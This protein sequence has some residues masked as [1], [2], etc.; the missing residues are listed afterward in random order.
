M[1][2]S[3]P[4]SRSLRK[5]ASKSSGVA[6]SAA[7]HVVILAAGQG[8][9][10]KSALPKVLHPIGGRPMLAHVLDTVAQLEAAACH[11]VHGHGADSV[12]TWCESAYPNAAGL[13]W[14]LQQ[15]QV[16]T[17][18]AVQQA[19]P[20]IPDDAV[21]LVLYA[22]VPL[23]RADTLRGLLEAARAG[24]ALLTAELADPRGYG[25]I[26]RDRRGN[27]IGIVEEKDASA[28]QRGIREI[29][30]GCS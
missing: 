25:R 29:N 3:K 20:E 16:G 21:V 15:Q 8:T 4:T 18:H 9:R 11:I 6:S 1:P 22:D 23:I 28:K 19:L 12:R 30:T 13:R 2:S 27:V 5:P 24:A 17:A 26:L 14:V 10:M 7:L